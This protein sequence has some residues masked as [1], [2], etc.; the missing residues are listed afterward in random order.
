MT[1]LDRAL[2][3]LEAEHQRLGK[4]SDF[5]ALNPALTL[6]RGDIPYATLAAQLGV[7]EPAARMAVHRLRKRFRQLFR[8]EIA[9]TVAEP[10]EVDEEIRQLVAALA[11]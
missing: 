3:R 1:L 2:N 4:G 8:E 9:L 7:S 11:G 6:D 5:A 10:D